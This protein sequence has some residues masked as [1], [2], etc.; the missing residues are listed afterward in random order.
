[1]RLLVDLD[2]VLADWDSNFD[3]H[4]I[5]NWSHLPEMPLTPVRRSFNFYDGVSP[6]V[7][8]GISAIMNHPGFYAELQPIPGGKQALHAMLEEG[9]D[10][11]ICTAPWLTNP[12]CASDKLAWV[13]EHIGEGWAK[14][15][16]ITKDKT[17]VRGDILIDDK[18]VITG[19]MVPEWEHVYFDRPY[20]EHIKEKKRL[21]QW[22]DWRH[23]LFT[24]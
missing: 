3:K 21:F 4:I 13:E 14:R 1:M 20:N 12:T 23:V 10:V 8:D 17:L 18:T 22:K 15:T 16:V 7:A 9:H 24:D 6:D 19:S 2:G 11:H 5:E